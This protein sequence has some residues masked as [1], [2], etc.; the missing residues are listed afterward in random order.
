MIREGSFDRILVRPRSA[1][2]QIAG[3]QFDGRTGRLALSL[4]IIVWAMSKAQVV[5]DLP[6]LFLILSILGGTC[7]MFYGLFVIQATICFWTVESLEIMNAVTYGGA[8]TASYPLTIY[9]PWFQ[10]LFT[11]VIPLGWVTF[12]PATLLLGR[13]E[14]TLIPSPLLWFAPCVGAIFLSLTFGF[15]NLGVRRYCSTG[16]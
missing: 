12:F 2:L 3:S 14:M 8:E 7:C 11:Y 13:H 15:W 1:S 10:H 16:S 9:R 4:G 6:H 5:W